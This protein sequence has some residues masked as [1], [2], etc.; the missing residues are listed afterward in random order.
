MAVQWGGEEQVQ[1]DFA[2]QMNCGGKLKVE[3]GKDNPENAKVSKGFLFPSTGAHLST[4][5]LQLAVH[6][7]PCSAK[8]ARDKKACR[9]QPDRR[10][11]SEKPETQSVDMA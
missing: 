11:Q 6:L 5:A 1:F 7:T 4:P 9:A 2:R 10:W 8:M 3:S